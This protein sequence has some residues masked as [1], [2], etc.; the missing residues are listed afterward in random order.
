MIMKR[1]KYI[2]FTNGHFVIFPAASDHKE[3]AES[4]GRFLDVKSAGHIEIVD[5][6]LDIRV[7]SMTPDI[8][9]T[10]KAQ[11]EDELALGYLVAY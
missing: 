8:K 7:G 10:E 1:G 9:Y 5:G 2:I 4:A 6:Q 11:Q 3:I